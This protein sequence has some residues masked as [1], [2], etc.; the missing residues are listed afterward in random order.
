MSKTVIQK[1]TSKAGKAS[2][3]KLTPAQRTARA[4]KAGLARAAKARAK[5][6]AAG[7]DLLR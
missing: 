2:A 1:L 6:K 3:A 4:L 7:K 5:A